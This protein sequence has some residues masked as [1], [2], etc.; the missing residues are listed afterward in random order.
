M[1]IRIAKRVLQ[2]SIII[3]ERK[4]SGS[5]H[6]IKIENGIGQTQDE[7]DHLNYESATAG[8][9]VAHAAATRVP[10]S[11]SVNEHL[12]ILLCRRIDMCASWCRSGCMAHASLALAAPAD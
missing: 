5:R 3:R 4:V 2:G 12:P 6:I 1:G 11:S 8:V 9:N 10:H 7:R